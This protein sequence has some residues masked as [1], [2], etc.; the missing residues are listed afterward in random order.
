[1][2]LDNILNSLVDKFSYKKKATVGG[3]TFELRMLNYEQDN[4]INSFPGEEDD[5]L[6][7]YEKTRSQILSYSICS[8]NGEEIPDIVKIEDSSKERSIYIREF[9]KKLP[10]KIVEKMFEIYVDFKEEM[11][12]KLS[13][14]IEYEWF[15]TPEERDKERKKKERESKEE[16]KDA[17][18][19]EEDKKDVEEKIDF[20]QI[21]ESDEEEA[22]E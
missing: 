11:D 5:P 16:E 21:K 22:I 8:I 4:S 14:D 1:M 2:S 6:S 13:N 18:S 12:S 19:F 3:I 20:I 10:P 7:F 17:S 9:L 15:K